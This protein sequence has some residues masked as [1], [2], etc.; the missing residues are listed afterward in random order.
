MLSNLRNAKIL[1]TALDLK[2][3]LSIFFVFIL[4]CAV[5]VMSI[6]DFTKN[7]SIKC[8]KHCKS[9]GLGYVYSPTGA[10]E[11]AIANSDSICTCIKV[12]KTSS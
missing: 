10:G 1:A 6:Q 12:N 4:L 5:F 8:M 3:P 7:E 11:G 9:F 2:F